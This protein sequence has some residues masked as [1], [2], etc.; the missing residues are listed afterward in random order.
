[1]PRRRAQVRS[2]LIR[3]CQSSLR[4]SRRSWRGNRASKAWSLCSKPPSTSAHSIR[5][6]RRV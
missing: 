2:R 3:S 5:C 6:S 1:L 4:P